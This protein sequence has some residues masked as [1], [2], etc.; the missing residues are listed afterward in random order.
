MILKSERPV[1]RPFLYLYCA[2]GYRGDGGP[3][4]GCPCADM[5]QHK[6]AVHTFAPTVYMHSHTGLSD[7]WQAIYTHT[8][9]HS[10]TDAPINT[11]TKEIVRIN[12]KDCNRNSKTQVLLP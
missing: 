11:H 6:H 5:L 4:F 7:F 3:G 9:R 1:L 8:H 12:S 2:M 10:D